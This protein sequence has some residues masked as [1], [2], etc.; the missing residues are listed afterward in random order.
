ML[1]VELEAY[2]G[3][4]P[5]LE[6]PPGILLRGSLSS[7]QSLGRDDAEVSHRGAHVRE[8]GAAESVLGDVYAARAGQQQPQQKKAA[9][10]G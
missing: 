6:E 3:S 2:D 1:I 4:D 8:A 7:P 10:G 9:Q 5:L